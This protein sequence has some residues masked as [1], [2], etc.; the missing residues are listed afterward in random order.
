MALCVL[1][2]DRKGGK[3]SST[4]GW[5]KPQL[6]I[7]V[8]LDLDPAFA[9]QSRCWMQQIWHATIKILASSEDRN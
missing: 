8:V 9:P 2:E 1:I 7:E 5:G 4:R 6:S 3:M